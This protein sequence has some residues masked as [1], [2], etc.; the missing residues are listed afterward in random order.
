MPLP[1]LL[2]LAALVLAPQLATAQ[3]TLTDTPRL[4]A[5]ECDGTDTQTYQ[6]CLSAT[7]AE[8]LAPSETTG[9]DLLTVGET[10]V[11]RLPPIASPDQFG[12]EPAPAGERYVRAGNDAVRIDTETRL[13]TKVIYDAL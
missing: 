7:L 3:S 10:L 1:R 6:S 4:D 2:T 12:L 5:V 8:Q 13:I 9:T 11:Q